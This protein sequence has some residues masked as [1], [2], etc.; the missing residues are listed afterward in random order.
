VAKTLNRKGTRGSWWLL[1]HLLRAGSLD[2]P[3]RFRLSDSIGIVVP[4]ARNHY[5][6]HDLHTYETEFV[7]SLGEAVRRLPGPVTLLD[8]GADIG[9]FSLKMLTVCPSISHII[10]FEPNS[11]GYPWLQMNL[12]S[13]PIAT[14]AVPSAVADFMGPGRLA[15]P[16]SA[17]DHTAFFIE[18]AAKGSIPVTTIDATLGS[19]KSSLVI[20]L[21]LEGGELAALRGAVKALAETPNVV[22]AIEAHPTVAQRTGIEPV[23]CLRFLAG[24]RPFRFMDGETRTHLTTD[25]PVFK[26]I[27]PNQIYN[28]ICETV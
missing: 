1:Q 9:L 15:S 11:E 4:I 19:L 24:L 3:V 12:A 16:A 8:C 22:V 10:A 28:L 2:R 17:A 7:A 13:L 25:R 20:K 21:D 26:Q 6:Q 14:E 27:P 18:P 23:E 5:D